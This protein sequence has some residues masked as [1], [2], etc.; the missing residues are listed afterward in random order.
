M[1]STIP[2]DNIRCKA[3]SKQTQERCKNRVVDGYTVCRFHGAN[4][5]NKGGETKQF[6]TGFNEEDLDILLKQ[7]RVLKEVEEDTRKVTQKRDI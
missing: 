1:A 7:F 4:P 2:P 5:K 6:P 3:K